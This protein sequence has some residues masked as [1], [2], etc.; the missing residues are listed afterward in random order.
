MLAVP[1][2]VFFYMRCC[3]RMTFRF[4]PSLHKILSLTSNVVLKMESRYTKC[5]IDPS[6]YFYL[7]SAYYK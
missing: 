4:D 1:F 5:L 3:H 2:S 6:I 7:H